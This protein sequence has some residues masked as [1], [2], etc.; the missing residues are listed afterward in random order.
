MP[1]TCTA[2]GVDA[3]WL[4][5]LGLAALLGMSVNHATRPQQQ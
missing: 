1:M 3:S 2:S 5:P 4:L